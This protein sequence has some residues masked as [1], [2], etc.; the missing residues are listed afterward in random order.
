MAKPVRIMPCLDIQNGR[1]VKGVQFIN[2]KD[3]GDPTACAAA[4]GQAGADELAMLDIKATLE[5]RST[6]LDVVRNAARATTIPI[7]VGGGISDIKTA[8]AAIDAGAA[9]VSISSAAFRR[10]QIIADTIK[11]LGS[12]KVTLAID[13]D[14][15][16][17]MASGYEVFID[18]GQTATNA[19][20]LEWTKRAA[21][22]GAT[23][24]LPTSKATDGVRTGYDLP[25]IR[26]LTKATSAEV[27]ASGGAGKLEHFLEAAMAGADILLAASVFHFGIITIPELK[28]FLLQHGVKT[29]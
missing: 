21:D 2:I 25:L 4:Y 28:S 11:E 27:V 10:P 15:N 5:G 19:D 12:D 23:C 9:R 24:I 22:M 17:R 6:M 18:G 8:A 29:A 16:P 1:V 14:R 26:M 20:A 13:V 3:A 7:T